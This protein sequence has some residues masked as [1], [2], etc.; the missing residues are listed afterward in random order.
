MISYAVLRAFLNKDWFKDYFAVSTK[1]WPRHDWE[2][3]NKVND[4]KHYGNVF[5]LHNSHISLTQARVKHEK[6]YSSWRVCLCVS[7]R[8]SFGSLFL[9]GSRYAA[10]QIAVIAAQWCLLLFLVRFSSLGRVPHF[11]LSE[12]CSFHCCIASYEKRWKYLVTHRQTDKHTQ[13]DT[14]GQNDYYNS[15]PTLVLLIVTHI[16]LL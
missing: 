6:G 8:R 7:N 4:Q 3:F 14:H 10:D 16:P 1:T 11:E 12:W 9:Q 2:N 13:T 15:P 5:L